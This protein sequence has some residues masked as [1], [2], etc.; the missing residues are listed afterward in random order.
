MKRTLALI[1]ALCLLAP[2]CT[3]AADGGTAAR[4]YRRGPQRR[5]DRRRIRRLRRGARQ[6]HGADGDQ[7]RRARIPGRPWWTAACWART[8]SPAPY[9]ELLPEGSGLEVTAENVNWC[10]PEM[11]V[12]ALATAG[13]TDA[14]G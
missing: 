4:R 2:L 5:A 13:I 7:R 11:Y 10:T 3:A 6:R 8:P 12:S 14:A 9:V 1:L